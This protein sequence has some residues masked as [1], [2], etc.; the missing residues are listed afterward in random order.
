MSNTIK[1][2]IITG[3]ATIVSAVIGVSFGKS[4]EQK[5][6]QYE[7]HTAMGDV[8]N[9]T[10]NNNEVTINNVKDL[11]DEYLNV[12]AQKESLLNGK[13]DQNVNDQ[14]KNEISKL[15]SELENLEAKNSELETENSELEAKNS[16]LEAKNSELEAKN[17]ELET[18]NSELEA[19][20]I[21]IF[22]LETFRGKG[23][24]RNST[25]SQ[26]SFTDTYGNKY[27]SAYEALH[28]WDGSYTY[29]NPPVYLLDKK[30]SKCQGQLAWPKEDKDKN[31]Y[32]W[33][34]FYA[35]DELL[36]TTEKI[37]ADDRALTFEFDVTN[38][39][40]LKIYRKASI[41][42]VDAIYPY[43]NLVK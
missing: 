36:Y 2:A 39:E 33:I 8:V 4:S 5:N 43:L 34:E 25:Y 3:I 35:D 28:I 12:L 27:Q 37:G 40:K 7:I 16:E 1:A 9:V 23:G 31:G 6:I 21:S 15:Q 38:V 14:L 11:V 19:K 41:P 17:S 18:E 32:I 30:Y 10:S 26:S 13:Q 42:S 29:Y 20:T 22:T 24:W